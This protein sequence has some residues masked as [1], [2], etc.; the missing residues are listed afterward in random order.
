MEA[1]SGISSSSL[2]LAVFFSRSGRKEQ[3][4]GR[5]R[6]LHHFR[7]ATAKIRRTHHLLRRDDNHGRPISG[8]KISQI[9]SGVMPTDR[10][11]GNGFRRWVSDLKI[12]AVSS[13]SP[14]SNN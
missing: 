13:S 5:G 7:P 8:K 4:S 14:N 12:Q 6:R 1:S 2:S 9:T 10:P 11:V 3:N